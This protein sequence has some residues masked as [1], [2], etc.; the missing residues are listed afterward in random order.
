MSFEGKAARAGFNGGA[1]RDY[2]ES[3]AN[4]TIEGLKEFIREIDEETDPTGWRESCSILPFHKM[5]EGV[6]G[7]CHG[8]RVIW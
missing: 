1:I 6:R 2:V 5:I 4:P 8:S 7:T 3:T